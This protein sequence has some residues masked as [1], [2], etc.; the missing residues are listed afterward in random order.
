MKEQGKDVEK[1]K[2]EKAEKTGHYYRLMMEHVDKV[3]GD[4]KRVYPGY[5]PA[6][7]HELAGFVW[8]QGWNDMVDSGTYPDRRK[9]GGYDIQESPSL[10]ELMATVD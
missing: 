10:F 6:Q 7:G 5:D 9:P 2:A 1:I 8:F 3:L 4:I